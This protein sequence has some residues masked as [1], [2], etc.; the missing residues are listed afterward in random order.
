MAA[1]C[2]FGV[3]LRTQL[4][5]N[6]RSRLTDG[7]PYSSSD[8]LSS[9]FSQP[10]AWPNYSKSNSFSLFHSLGQNYSKSNSSSPFSSDKY[11][12][13]QSS[14][15]S[16]FPG[17]TFLSPTPHLQNHSKSNFLCDLEK[18]PL[19]AYLFHTLVTGV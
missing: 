9:S 2:Y 15:F 16:F 14:F 6:F 19:F 4:D 3:D 1:C 17:L 18:L 5:H 10:F 11:I 12:L 13:S 8:L 7:T